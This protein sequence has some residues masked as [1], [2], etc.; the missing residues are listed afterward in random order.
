MGGKQGAG[1]VF[2]AGVQR[3]I[4]LRYEIRDFL[5]PL[6]HQ[7]H[8]HGLDTACR[9]AAADLLPQQRRQLV[10][11]DAVQHAAG[12][13]GVHQILIDVAGVTD[14]VRH[15]LFGDLIERDPPRLLIRQVQKML[16]MPA[17]GFAFAVRVGGEVDG[18]APL[19][20]RLELLDDILFALDGP[21][22]G[23]EIPVHVH[24]QR[25][26]GQVPQVAH[27]GLHLIIGAQIL[28]DGLGF[29][30][31]LHDHQILCFC[32]NLIYSSLSSTVRRK[33]P[34]P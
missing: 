12:L 20:R 15:H 17:D 27:T 13:L 26:L 16:Q 2:Q 25:A 1:V 24:A 29:G 34:A 28:A 22:I 31:G 9:Q 5:F 7:T 30:G 14:A 19:C 3:P 18:L 32:H 10:A 11:H 33:L 8:G 23:G 6:G 21:V 4:L